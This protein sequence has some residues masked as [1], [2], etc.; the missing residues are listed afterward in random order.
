MQITLTDA[1]ATHLRE[2]LSESASGQ[3][4]RVVFKGFG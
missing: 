3:G 1:A 2:A 4:V